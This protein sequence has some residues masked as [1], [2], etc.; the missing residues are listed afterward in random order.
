M[1]FS[2]YIK[3][4]FNVICNKTKTPAER[5]RKNKMC[6]YFSVTYT[7]YALGGIVCKNRSFGNKKL[8][9]KTK[10]GDILYSVGSRSLPCRRP[11]EQKQKFRFQSIL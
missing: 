10:K 1:F 11:L 2:R 8:L 4:P 7:I 5:C 3:R 9:T 6:A